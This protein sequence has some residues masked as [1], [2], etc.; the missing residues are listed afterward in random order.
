MY[1]FQ[2]YKRSVRQKNNSIILNNFLFF[3]R[4]EETL[5]TKIVKTA[6]VTEEVQSY[7]RD[8]TA[9]FR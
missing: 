3:R 1:E 5:L 6:F 4:Y 7:F 9:F 8:T 2:L